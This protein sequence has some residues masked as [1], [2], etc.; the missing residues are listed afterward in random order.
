[1]PPPASLE[2]SKGYRA[3]R[4]PRLALRS[5]FG[6]RTDGKLLRPGKNVWRVEQA[7][8]AAVLI[9]AAAF[10]R[11]VR[12]ALCQAQ[13]TVFIVG[14]D[15]DSRCRLVGEDCDPHDGLP[16][17]FADF[18]S[19]IVR[20]RPE[21]TVHLLLWD[22]SVLYA[23]ERELF[24]TLALHW[25]TPRQ[26]RLCLDDEV[27]I[28]SSHHQKIIVV[29]DAVAFS[30]GLDL[31]VRR[32]D[33]PDHTLDNPD[34]VDPAGKPYRPFHDV[35]ALVDG[36]AAH[37]LAELVRARWAQ[38]S[39]DFPTEIDPLGD[40]WPR[41]VEPD[42]RHVNVGIARTLPSY[43]ERPEVREVE[44]LFCDSFAQ[45]R[46]TIY[47]E[48]QFVTCTKV[49]EQLARTMRR[50]PELE[51]LIIAPQHYD[52]WI[53]ARTMRNGRIRFLHMLQDAGVADRVRLLYPQVRDGERV[54]DTMI[55]SKICVIDDRLLRVGSANL[56][57]RSMGADTECDLVF[58]AT[59]GEQRRRIA[60]VRNKLFGEH[61][62]A[63]AEEIAESLQH[64]GSIIRTAEQITRNGHS[65]QPIDDGEPD[66]DELSAA[67]E[68][69]ADPARPL[70]D[71]LMRSGGGMRLSR[72]QLSTLLKIALA[73][74]VIVALPLIWEYTPLSRLADPD[75]VRST[76][77][78][79]S[80]SQWA[81]LAVVGIFVAG[82][83]VAFPVLVLIAVTAATFGPLYGFIYGLAGSLASALV[84]YLIG[85]WLGKDLLRDLLGPRLDRI[86]RRIV[87]QG[88][89]SVAAIRVVPV[90]P[91]TFVNLV[92]GASQ[93]RLH[94]YLAGTVLGMAPGLIVMSALGHQVFQILTRPTLANVAMLGAAIIGWIAVSIG[95]Q[96]LVS[97]LRK[98]E[99]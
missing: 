39:C 70:T 30:G 62:G 74:I 89:I 8:R 77:A 45:A 81:P 2:I 84:T 73:A 53:E 12:E 61:C 92:A 86:R 4:R 6:P 37:A 64:T 82:G 88:V 35:Q 54:T 24:P 63:T 34:R 83:L 97:R 91:F 10:F 90:A 36:P 56:N 19:A 25:N 42:L 57:N 38:A 75:V 22:Y 27:P 33:T 20:Q 85:R 28:G 58:E 65:L 72:P 5:P 67:I 60:H 1:M 26:V 43:I 32:W 21:L 13:R 66:P 48:N 41:S 15:I 76:L 3:A 46:R 55:H 79:I 31:T 44:Q 9:D 16:V 98:A 93:I 99:P 7:P 18:L 50:R 11:A 69:V 94:D 23:L 47:I 78:R 49:S 17:A 96:V 29:D 71:K 68:E 80:A 51:T 14:W 59:N 40:P 95:V 87:N 52:S